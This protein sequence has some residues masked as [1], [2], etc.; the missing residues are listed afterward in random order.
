ML[1]LIRSGLMGNQLKSPQ[2]ARF[3]AVVLAWVFPLLGRAQ[4]L[5]DAL[6]TTNLVWTTGGDVAWFAQTTNTY[7]GVDAARSGMLGANQTSWI[8]TTVTGP[9][10]LDY[11]IG[12]MPGETPLGLWII[13]NNDDSEQQVWPWSSIPVWQEIIHDL[14]AG[15]QTFRWQVASSQ[16][17][18]N[19]G[20][21]ILDEFKVLPPRPL[22]VSIGPEEQTLYSGFFAI[23]DAGTLTGIPPIH[24]QWRKDGVDIPNATNEWFYI[25]LLTTNDSGNYTLY[26]SNS[27][28]TLVSSNALLS[29]VSSAP[30]FTTEPYSATGYTGQDS[31]FWGS[32]KG[33]LPFAYQWRKNG[34]NLTDL[35]SGGWGSATLTLTNVSFADAGS[36]TLFVT[37]DYGSIESSNAVLTVLPSIAPTITKHPRSLEVAEGVNTWLSVDAAGDPTSCGNWI[38]ADEP[39]SQPG[40]PA[41][42][43][44]CQSVPL[45]RSFPN[46]SPTNAGVYFAQI[47]NAGGTTNSRSALLTVLPPISLVNTTAQSAVE[48]CVTNQLAFLA[49]GNAGF[50]ILSVSNPAAPVLLG[51][52]DTPGYAYAVQVAGSLAY[53]A[54]NSALRI[55]S[56]TNP[57]APALVGTY[58]ATSAVTDVVI[59]SNLAFIAANNAGLLILNVSNPAAPTLVGSY[60]TNLSP[61]F[62]ALSGDYAYLTSLPPTQGPGG[63]PRVGG[64]LIVNIAN[65]AQPWEAGRF[66]S[67]FTRV[68]ARDGI[69]FLTGGAGLTVA[70]ARDPQ[71]P[72]WIGNFWNYGPTIPPSLP[73]YVPVAE[74]QLVGDRIYL[75]GYSGTNATLLVLDVRN[76]SEPI[77]VGYHASYGQDLT[78]AVEGN[79][80]FIG[81]ADQQFKVFETP[82]NVSP[83]SKPTL[84][85]TANSGL[86]LGIHGSR[87][88]NFSLEASAAVV[89]QSWQP[90]RTV[91]LTNDSSSVTITQPVGAQFF[92]LLQ[93]D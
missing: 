3:G 15:P 43:Q 65:P 92:R 49:Q 40:I 73:H 27:Q 53:V 23:I 50:S 41:P 47:S 90:V 32:F 24:L 1:A 34:T 57:A 10:T 81:G 44:P 28:G 91:L 8:E 46:V 52:Y 83:E 36:Y 93:L 21:V 75:T 2:Y 22:S 84:S 89:G 59:R 48:L 25:P 76:P 11:F 45:Q 18:T 67:S 85:I 16:S 70:D 78:I 58:S 29:V 88:R 4:S 66:G 61:R 72:L 19:L 37:N 71:T 51:S 62:L 38:R 77:P 12:T 17:L 9:A 7:D 5:A 33:S 64:M 14:P 87:G 79:R 86:Q 6:D 74:F 68:A 20:F 56:V 80:V 26:A 55:F 42:P 82:F 69:V 60:G 13:E 39:Y 35:T 63:N 30:I 54:D 31:G